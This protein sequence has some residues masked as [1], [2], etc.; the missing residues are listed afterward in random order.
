M[1][2]LLKAIQQQLKDYI[3]QNNLRFDDVSDIRTALIEI[4][5]ELTDHDYE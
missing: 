4:A 3:N 2:E 1:S 5:D